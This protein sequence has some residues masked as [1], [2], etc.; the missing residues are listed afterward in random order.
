MRS[1]RGG[2]SGLNSR[3]TTANA[4][5]STPTS[6]DPKAGTES[7]AGRDY[8]SHRYGSE[9]GLVDTAAQKRLATAAATGTDMNSSYES[10]EGQALW[11][12]M[13]GGGSDRGK[14]LSHSASAPNRSKFECNM[15]FNYFWEYVP[16]S[17]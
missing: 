5:P 9:E 7:A 1:P 8:W 16:F 13:G 2:S 14:T 10:A 12:T 4:A 15:L 17:K 11:G 3:G 6:D